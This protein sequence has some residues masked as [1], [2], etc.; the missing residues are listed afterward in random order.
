MGSEVE[1]NEE[2][3]DL[4]TMIALG[5]QKELRLNG[6]TS[7]KENCYTRSKNERGDLKIAIRV[8]NDYGLTSCENL[9]VEGDSGKVKA[10]ETRCVL[11]EVWCFKNIGEE[12]GNM[13]GWS[14]NKID[15]QLIY[16]KLEIRRGIKMTRSMESIGS[17]NRNEYKKAP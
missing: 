16:W 12:R 17:K 14:G 5:S 10:V 4:G 8:G 9:K 6:S 3:C 13:I 11:I 2:R 7:G 1:M 15:Q